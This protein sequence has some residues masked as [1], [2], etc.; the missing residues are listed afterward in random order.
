M[1]VGNSC[2]APCS[3]ET[4]CGGRPRRDSGGGGRRNVREITEG[5]G[6]AK[7]IPDSALV[8]VSGPAQADVGWAGKVVTVKV[9]T[10]SLKKS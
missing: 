4:T 2:A 10:V 7:V 8:L 3:G 1:A 6:C 5:H 9:S